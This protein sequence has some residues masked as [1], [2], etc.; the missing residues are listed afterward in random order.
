MEIAA[1]GSDTLFIDGIDR[2]ETDHQP[3][4]LDI[5]RTILR[6]LQLDNWKI[7][8]SLRDTGIEP[9]RNWLGEV[10]AT[11]SLASVEIGKLAD[12]E[13][14]ALAQGNPQLR[15]LLFGPSQVREIVR[16]PFFAKILNQSFASESVEPSFEP[17]SEVD[18]L[19]NW[20]TRGGYNAVGQNA[21]ERQ[22]AIIELGTARA[23]HLSRPVPLSGLTTGT[24][25]LIEQLVADG[26]LQHVQKGHTVRFA[27]DIF[28]EWSF[29]DLL[30]DHADTWFDE[31]HTCCEP[32]AVARVVELLS[33]RQYAEDVDWS[34]TLH[35]IASSSM[36]SQWTRAWLL[37]PLASFAIERDEE[38]FSEAVLVDEYRFLRKTLVWFQ[39]EKTTPNPNILAGDMPRDQ[40]IRIADLLGWPSDFAAWRRLI[41]FLLKKVNNVPVALYPN[42]LSVFDVWQNALAGMKNRVSRAIVTQ[43]ADWLREIDK[44]GSRKA[45]DE[46]SRWSELEELGDFR[47]SLGRL[48]FRSA[49]PY[50]KFTEE[51]L[52]RIIASERLRGDRLLPP[53]AWIKVGNA[54]PAACVADGLEFE[55]DEDDVE[56]RESGRLPPHT[57]IQNTHQ[58]S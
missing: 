37:G 10:L 30:A 9:L 5:L 15:A 39:A 6:S 57:G 19:T 54:S 48:I 14:E 40:R 53:P 56:S 27:H 41:D 43:C 29:F 1:T 36:R 46:P 50:P 4:V 16:R 25:G 51:Y 7:I 49:A 3:I 23:R 20:W 12:D 47:N 45:S 21:I 35:L 38:K 31:I 8:V 33:E 44:A 32:P 18:L 34:A 42:I 13:A 24:I 17:Q 26:I 28:F 55:F 52:K 58:K 22:R 2:I 11:V